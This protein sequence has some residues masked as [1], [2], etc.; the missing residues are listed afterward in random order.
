[1]LPGRFNSGGQPGSCA[2]MTEEVRKTPTIILIVLNVELIRK[3]GN[4]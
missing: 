4:G 2:N 3:G 1:M